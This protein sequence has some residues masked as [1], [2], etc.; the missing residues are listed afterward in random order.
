MACLLILLG[1][2]IVQQPK[3]LGI[4]EKQKVLKEFSMTKILILDLFPKG[5]L[6]LKL[7]RGSSL[8]KWASSLSKG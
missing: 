5:R 2:E 6:F 7:F 8:A 4:P 3:G 1:V